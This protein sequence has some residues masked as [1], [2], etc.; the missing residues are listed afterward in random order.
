VK[1]TDLSN[2]TTTALAWGSTYQRSAVDTGSKLLS[3]AR[4]HCILRTGTQTYVWTLEQHFRPHA[5][6]STP[7]HR[8]A[9]TKKRTGCQLFVE[10]RFFHTRYTRTTGLMNI[11]IHQEEPVATK[12]TNLIKRNT[13]IDE[14]TKH[15]N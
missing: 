4:R 15:V 13:T 7:S 2:L 6:R 10:R 9:I 14:N 8:N 1:Y 11:F 12:K 5:Q 3:T